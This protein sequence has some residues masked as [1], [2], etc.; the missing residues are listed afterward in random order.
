MS[1]IS[2]SIPDTFSLRTATSDLRPTVVVRDQPE[3]AI[4]IAKRAVINLSF[5]TSYHF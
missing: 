1:C 2:F 5:I 3:R 4:K